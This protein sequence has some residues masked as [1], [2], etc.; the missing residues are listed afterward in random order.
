[1]SQLEERVPGLT[2]WLMIMAHMAVA[3]REEEEMEDEVVRMGAVMRVGAVVARAMV[4]SVAVGGL[5]VEEDQEEVEAG[6]ASQ[7]G[8]G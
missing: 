1:M 8:V 7:V 6:E 5:K 4:G 2:T 3:W